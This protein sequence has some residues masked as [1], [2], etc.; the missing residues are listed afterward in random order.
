MPPVTSFLDS[1]R[2]SAVKFAPQPVN[3]SKRI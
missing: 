1:D 3:E 2:L